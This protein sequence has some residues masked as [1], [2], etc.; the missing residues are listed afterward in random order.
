MTD[1]DPDAD[2]PARRR[3]DRARGGGAG[4]PALLDSSFKVGFKGPQDY[5]TEV[6]GETEELISDRPARG[7][8]A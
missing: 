2:A 5:L 4:A 7:L 8:S 6:D 1:A 3:G